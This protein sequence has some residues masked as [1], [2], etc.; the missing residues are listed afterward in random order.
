MYKAYK[1]ITFSSF[2]SWGTLFYLYN[3][4][5]LLLSWQIY[6]FEHLTPFIPI[7][8]LSN[9]SIEKCYW[10]LNVSRCRSST[11]LFGMLVSKMHSCSILCCILSQRIAKHQR[12][13]RHIWLSSF[14]HRS[15]PYIENSIDTWNVSQKVLPLVLEP[16]WRVPGAPLAQPNINISGYRGTPRGSLYFFVQLIQPAPT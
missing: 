8:Y 14:K 3:F 13:H 10:F 12:S 4:G 11:Y 1:I 7:N 9:V 2:P 6:T 5:I 16:H 15:M